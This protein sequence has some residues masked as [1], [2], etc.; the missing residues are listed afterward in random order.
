[1]A[2][3]LPAWKKLVYGSGTY[4]LAAFGMLRQIFYAIFLTDVVGLD[5]RLASIGALVG[6]FWDALNDPLVGLLSDR[7]HSRWG[8]R[9]PFLLWFTIPFAFSFVIL[10]WAP[11]W[12]SQIALAVYVTL[13]FMLSD[14]VGT[15]IAVPYTAM[16]PELTPDYDERTSLAGYRMFFQLAASLTIAIAAPSIVDTALLNGLSQQ[17]GYLIV[18]G[19]FGAIAVLPLMLIFFTIKDGD[20]E[21]PDESALDFL[22]AMRTTWSNI[23]FRFAAFLNMLNWMAADLVAL[24]IPYYLLYWI[25]RGDLTASVQLLGLS[26]SLESGVLGLLILT[27]ILAIPFWSWL[28]ARLSKRATYLIGVTPWL[29]GYVALIFVQ[30]GQVNLMLAIAAFA[31]LGLATGY[32]LPEAIFPDVIEWDELLTR[33]RQEGIYYGIKNFF[34]KISG[35]V[36]FF[37]ALQMLGW[38]GYQT[39]PEGALNFMQPESALRV[40]RFLVGPMGLFLLLGAMALA[41]F[42]PLSRERH[43]RIRRLLARRKTRGEAT[44]NT[45]GRG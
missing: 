30:P 22:A 10:W 4:G 13:A 3:R 28:A 16:T 32:V 37:L 11:P 6:I 18:S 12:E 19:L 23:P 44:E 26:L 33:R 42:Y 14:T 24:I 5:P 31:G 15:L 9:R 45:T 40:I 27:A 8:R 1:M 34:R 25:A 17:Q 35:A 41:A 7:V 21:K 43:A 20:R 2:N 39:P 29:L 38:A 36:A